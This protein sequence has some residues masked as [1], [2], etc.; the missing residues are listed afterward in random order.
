MLGDAGFPKVEQCSNQLAEVALSV[1]AQGAETWNVA[2]INEDFSVQA[3]LK[4]LDG[5]PRGYLSL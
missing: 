3:T 5:L 2:K 4:Q 1:S